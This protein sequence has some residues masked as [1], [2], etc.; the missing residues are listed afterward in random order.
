MT[1]GGKLFLFLS[2]IN[3]T[4]KYEETSQLIKLTIIF[5]AMLAFLFGMH[6]F[7][8]LVSICLEKEVYKH[9]LLKKCCPEDHTELTDQRVGYRSDEKL[10]IYPKE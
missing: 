1:E 5:Y 10:F 3:F 4:T 2:L 9:F 6:L 8:L 7:F